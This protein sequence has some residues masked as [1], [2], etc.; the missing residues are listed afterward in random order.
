MA[1]PR[2]VHH[3]LPWHWQGLDQEDAAA[4]IRGLADWV[5]WFVSR[6]HL[7]GRVPACWYRH[8]GLVDELKGLWYEHQEVTNPLVAEVA[9]PF[10]GEVK[11]EDPKVSARLYRGWHEA[12]CR[13]TQ[14][15]LADAAGY[16][17]CLARNRHVE[18]EAH[19]ADATTFADATRNGLDEAFEAGELQW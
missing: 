16:R 11:A 5:S 17:E 18:D 1:A 13:W 14:G 3:H 9:G 7:A 15:P 19:A 12:R 6:Y 2:K 8:P 10:P 4:R